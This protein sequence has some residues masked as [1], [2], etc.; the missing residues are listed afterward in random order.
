MLDV[1]PNWS[2]IV[3]STTCM[4]IWHAIMY[5]IHGIFYSA[6]CGQLGSFY[7]IIYVQCTVMMQ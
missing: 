6:S 2:R 5:T 7:I 1:I 3:V 4:R